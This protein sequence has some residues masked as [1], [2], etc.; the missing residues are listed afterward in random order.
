M[1]VRAFSFW[2]HCIVSPESLE[3]LRIRGDRKETNMNPLISRQA[4]AGATACIALVAVA[5]SDAAW[6][7]QVDADITQVMPAIAEVPALSTHTEAFAVAATGQYMTAELPTGP[8][9]VSA[10]PAKKSPAGASTRPRHFATA[11]VVAAS[12]PSAD[13][14]TM[15]SRP[16]STSHD[17]SAFEQKRQ[18]RIAKMHAKA[19]QLRVWAAQ[20]EQAPLRYLPRTNPG[21]P[22]AERFAEEKLLERIAY[23]E[24]KA[25]RLRARA[26]RID[27]AA[28]RMQ[29]QAS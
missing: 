21:N 11:A 7:T 18:A 23:L 22:E 14:E 4:I 15:E 17:E 25:A 12:A 29:P 5:V 10:V 16:L 26:D 2:N 6:Q 1:L 3:T 19:Q 27:A 24:E 20:A 13:A 28:A 8:E 9:D